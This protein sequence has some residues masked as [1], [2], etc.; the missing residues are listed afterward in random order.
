MLGIIVGVGAV[1][2][3]VAIGSGASAQVAA[4]IESLGSN[5][6]VVQPGSVKDRG[7]RGGYGTGVSLTRDDGVAIRAQLPTVLHAAPTV[8]GNAQIVF[9]NSNWY[10]RV[11]GV[12]PDY[13]TVRNFEIQ[14]GAAFTMADDQIAARVAIIGQTIVNE[15][16]GGVNP[17]GQQMRLNS[18]P[19]IV[20][21]TLKPKGQSPTGEDQDDAILVPLTTAKRKLLG[22]TWADANSV[23]TIYVQARSAELTQRTEF[24]VRDL[25]RYRHRLRDGEADDF[26]VRNLTSRY[27]A[28]QESMEAMTILLA[29]IASVS[30]L[31]GGIGIMNIMLVSVTERTKEIGLRQAVGAKTRDILSQF[32][33]ESITL[34]LLGGVL[35]IVLGALTSHLLSA[36]AGWATLISPKAVAVAFVFSALVGVFFGYYPARKAAFLDPIEALR[37]E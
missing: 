37:Y 35:G 12:T 32:L 22:R 16:F 29:S 8:R 14:D 9:G 25:L 1:I 27:E 28:R 11:E 7:A 36:I 31:V 4:Q 21:A 6:L 18:H 17:V 19:F 5:M 10:S 23:R 20:V 3:M 2:A 24:D 26:Q 33:V 15:V 13:L 34:S 30:L